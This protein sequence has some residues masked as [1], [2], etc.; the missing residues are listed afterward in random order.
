MRGY[1]SVKKDLR[2]WGRAILEGQIARCAYLHWFRGVVFSCNIYTS[3]M[4]HSVALS[5]E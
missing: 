2:W 4:R 3:K 1:R 5:L